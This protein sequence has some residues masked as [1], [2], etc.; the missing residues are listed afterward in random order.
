MMGIA[1]GIAIGI[2]VALGVALYVYFSFTCFIT[3]VTFMAAYRTEFRHSGS[4]EAGLRSA[5]NVFKGRAPFNVL[6]DGE[7]ARALEVFYLVPDARSVAMIVRDLDRKKDATLLASRAFLDR[8]ETE[9]RG[10]HNA[11]DG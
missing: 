10:M 9:Y 5:M 11:G 8:L 7:L 3:E 1:I 6:A 4:H 2:A